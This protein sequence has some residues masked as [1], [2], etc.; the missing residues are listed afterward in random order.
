MA[1]VDLERLERRARRGYELARV[2]R[3]FVGVAPVLLIAACA[4]FVGHQWVAVLV[5]AAAL[6]LTGVVVLWYG[7]GLPRAFVPGVAA[8]IVPLTFALCAKHIGHVCTGSSCMSVCLPMCAAGG[9]LAGL[10]V[11]RFGV[12]ERRGIGYWVTASALTLLT[13]T[14]GCT[15]V[16]YAG[17]AGL[18]LGF[19]VSASSVAAITRL[20]LR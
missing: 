1:S 16:G 11:A 6:F 2:R 20:R 18:A 15:C 12:T 8:G 3:A 5:V 13:G 7:H 19:A 14:M 10:I 17:I 9:L 4:G